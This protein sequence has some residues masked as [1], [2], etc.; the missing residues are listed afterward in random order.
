[1]QMSLVLTVLSDDRPGLVKMLSDVLKEYQGNWTESRMIHLAGKFAGLLMV[2]VPESEFDDLVSALHDLEDDGLEISV[3]ATASEIAADTV[4][5]LELEVL[6]QDSP[7]IIN[8]MT[9]QL[10]TLS[11]NI[12]ELS[13]EQRSAPMSA[14]LLF[15]AKLSLGLPKDVTAQQVQDALEELPNQL[16]V[17][18]NFS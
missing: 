16:M 12:E 13:S 9:N 3:D 11:V 2:S 6:G 8:R 4:E 7:G 1:M 15:Y 18:I 17:D 5:T 10:L 14:E